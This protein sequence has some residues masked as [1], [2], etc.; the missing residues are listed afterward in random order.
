MFLD[1][2]NMASPVDVVNGT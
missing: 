1:H 2:I